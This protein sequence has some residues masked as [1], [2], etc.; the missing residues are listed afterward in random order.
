MLHSPQEY[1]TIFVT[2]NK[3]QMQHDFIFV[4]II[5]CILK[6]ADSVFNVLC[7]VEGGG[8]CC[9]FEIEEEFLSV[10]FS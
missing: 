3:Q 4:E 2:E 6:Y 9:S 1:G 10:I 8:P 5:K 7:N